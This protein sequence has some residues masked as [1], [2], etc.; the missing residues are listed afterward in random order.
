MVYISDI[1]LKRLYY[2]FF[3]IFVLRKIYQTFNSMIDEFVKVLY[4]AL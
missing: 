2:D 4:F 3:Q 1:E